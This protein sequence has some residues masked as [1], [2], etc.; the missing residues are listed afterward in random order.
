MT[1]R[2][3]LTITHSLPR[4]CFEEFM[5]PLTATDAAGLKRDET[6][7]WLV[8]TRTTGALRHF[9]YTIK[10]GSVSDRLFHLESLDPEPPPPKAKPTRTLPEVIEVGMEDVYEVEEIREK[11]VTK[12]RTEYLIKWEDWPE[13]TNTWERPSRI[14]PALVAAFEGKPLPKPAAVPEPSLPPRPR[15]GVGCARARL[16]QAE[17]RRGGV[18]QTMSMVCG[19]V[20]V[21][22]K[23]RVK[24]DAMPTL[25]LTFFVMTMDKNGHV[26]WP[27]DFEA[28]TR[29][30]LRVQARALLQRMI[31]DPLNPADETMAPALTA[32]GTDSVF[33]PAR[34]RKLVEV[35]E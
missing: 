6:T 3:E 17:E 7:G 8:P 2:K 35:D 21:H 10:K 26:T 4:E 12:G 1:R 28:K 15:R 31:D 25:K 20:I 34:K 14:D 19:H 33:K 18:P 22:F 30:Q 23:E 27:I 11:R 9:E 16:S 5:K 13:D 29:A 32:K 24:E